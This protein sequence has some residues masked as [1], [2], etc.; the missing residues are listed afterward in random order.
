MK[1]G[2]EMSTNMKLIKILGVAATVVGMG[3]TLISSWVADKKLDVKI[4]EKVNEVLTSNA[5]KD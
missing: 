2:E 4:S 3:A 5:V 1:G